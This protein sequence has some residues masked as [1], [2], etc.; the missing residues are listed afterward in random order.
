[1][2]VPVSCLR[3]FCGSFHFDA[4]FLERICRSDFDENSW[5]LAEEKDCSS[6]FIQYLLVPKISLSIMSQKGV[7]SI[8]KSV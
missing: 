6:G 7:K 1:M 2:T 3:T 4:V 5:M 8:F